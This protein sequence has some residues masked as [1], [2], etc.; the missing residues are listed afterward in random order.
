MLVH[1]NELYCIDVSQAVELDHPRAFDFLR[2][3]EQLSWGSAAAWVVASVWPPGRFSGWP[4]HSPAHA[5][6]PGHHNPSLQTASTRTT[7]SGARAWP[8]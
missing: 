5:H 4:A 7:S 6:H 2:E 3:G 8:R 1:N